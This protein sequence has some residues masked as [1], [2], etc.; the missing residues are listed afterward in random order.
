M[1]TESRH[2]PPIDD[3]TEG[4][5]TPYPSTHPSVPRGKGD[6]WPSPRH[7]TPPQEGMDACVGSAVVRGQAE[8]VQLGNLLE[9]GAVG[10]GRKGESD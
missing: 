6:G 10:G 8:V 7:A 4:D 1:H 3:D 5:D 9:L 2:G